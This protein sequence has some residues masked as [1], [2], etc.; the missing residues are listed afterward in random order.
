MHV[1]TG[2]RACTDAQHPFKN[3][4]RGLTAASDRFS[5]LALSRCTLTHK[6]SQNRIASSCMRAPKK[7]GNTNC[8]LK[9]ESIQ[10]L[11]SSQDWQRPLTKTGHFYRLWPK[12]PGSYYSSTERAAQSIKFLLAE[13]SGCVK[14]VHTQRVRARQAVETWEPCEGHGEDRQPPSTL[15]QRR[16]GGTVLRVKQEEI[17]G[18]E[19]TEADIRFTDAEKLEK[20][21]KYIEPSACFVKD[22]HPPTQLFPTVE[23]M[24]PRI[25]RAVQGSGDLGPA[26][27]PARRH[28]QTDVDELSGGHAASL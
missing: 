27:S 5:Q 19:W 28:I 13:D 21:K 4:Q 17:D 3:N 6:D 18:E 16:T 15:L 14:P 10:Y 25:V 12:R 7:N 1:G 26:H 9:G 20:K 23:Q 2:M 22:H 8:I 11:I 24:R